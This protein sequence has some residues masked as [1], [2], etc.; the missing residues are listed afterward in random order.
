MKKSICLGVVT[1]FPEES[2]ES[3]DLVAEM[4]LMHLRQGP[5]EHILADM[6][7]PPYRK[8]FQSIFGQRKWAWNLDRLI[9][10]RIILRQGV[11]RSLKIKHYDVIYIVDH[12]YAHLVNIIKKNFPEIPV[13][14]MCHDL[15]A[16][17]VLDEPCHGIRMKKRL[18]RW[19]SRP[20]LE[21]LSNAN[22]II[23]GS[24]T[25]R[26]SILMKYKSRIQPLQ[27]MTNPYGIATEF[28]ANCEVL[29]EKMAI[30]SGPVILHVG[31]VIPRKRID[32]LLNAVA[33]IA[34]Q[35]ETMTLI[36]IGGD[37]TTDQKELVRSLGLVDRVRVMPR[38]TRVE[39]AD[40]YRRSDVV[41]ITS[42]AEGFGLPVIEALACGASVVVSDIDVLRETGGRFVQYAPV[43]DS[44]KFARL[45]V[46]QIRDSGKGGGQG[47]SAD[48]LTS[49]LERY[50][51]AVHLERL[52]EVLEKE[53]CLKAAR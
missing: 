25:V 37:F 48:G 23:T 11:L 29:Q 13:V 8:I 52:V 50:Q 47:R 38:L 36:R 2:W 34:E 31:S 1:D 41:L 10:R 33:I 46:E 17:S 21:G 7:T 40:W 20:I 18:L 39:V 22:L 9:N 32:V 3:M 43:G 14:I 5:Y 4:T 30:S 42:E 19:F 24:D 27:L 49:H 6:I 51:W 16:V 26:D 45:A 35:V 28:H 12:S 53:A 15:D 44:E